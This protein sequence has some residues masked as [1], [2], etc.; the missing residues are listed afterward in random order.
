[1]IYCYI[2]QEDE[3]LA[4][5]V[6][7]RLKAKS[8]NHRKGNWIAKPHH[9]NSKPAQ[10]LAD[11]LGEVLQN[12]VSTLSDVEGRPNH[13]LQ[14]EVETKKNINTPKTPDV[15]PSEEYAVPTFESLGIPQ[16]LTLALSQR[17]NPITLPNEVQTKAIPVLLSPAKTVFLKA[18]TGTGKTLAFLLPLLTLVL[19][20]QASL[21]RDPRI[22]VVVVVPARELVRQMV[23][24]INLL[25]G[26]QSAGSPNASSSHPQA[27]TTTT[28]SLTTTSMSATVTNKNTGGLQGIVVEAVMGGT[29]LEEDAARL[30]QRVPAI[31]VGSAKRLAQLFENNPSAPTPFFKTLPSLHHAQMVVFDEADKIFDP[32]SRY[33]SKDEKTLRKIK[34]RPGLEFLADLAR[35]NSM[36]R[37][38]CAS[39]TL[40]SRLEGEFIH[41]GWWQSPARVSIA[42][43]LGLPPRLSHRF[44][45]TPSTE[46][47]ERWATLRWVFHQLELSSALLFVDK[48]KPMAPVLDTLRTL[49]LKVD[50][51]H[52]RLNLSDHE[53]T[54]FLADFRK[55]GAEGVQLVVATEETA[56]GLDFPGLPC[57]F[58]GTPACLL[59]P[60]T[61]LHLAGRTARNG[62]PGVVISIITEQELPLIRKIEAWLKIRMQE[63]L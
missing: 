32:L 53:R 1:M 11:F 4:E 37:F 44:V 35:V 20:K 27:I 29:S 39:A 12:N 56:R 25:L 54:K 58:L 10:H 6:K 46:P 60:R 59:D 22:L 24:E 42:R 43:P 2:F 48:T 47:E 49:D 45:I 40:N 21:A 51:L 15:A 26:F 57:V 19:E 23:D 9:M 3:A 30:S 17:E 52:A 61:Y 28:T 41:S 8:S 34:P 55:G 38:V 31:L 18:P 62:Q 5:S 7:Q 13:I 14:N 63:I 33:A 16:K 36:F 50:A